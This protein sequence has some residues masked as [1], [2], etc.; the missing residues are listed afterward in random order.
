[1]SSELFSTA[2]ETIDSIQARVKSAHR[3]FEGAQVRVALARIDS[4]T[5]FLTGTM[6]F[7][8]HEPK[9]RETADYGHIRLSEFWIKGVD[10]SLSFVGR[11]FDGKESVSG[12]PI[13][14]LFSRSVTHRE[15]GRHSSS[16]WPSWV[17]E[18]SAVSIDGQQRLNLEPIPTVAKGLPPFRS[19]SEAVA[20]W[21]GQSPRIGAV[22][23]DVPQQDQFVVVIP[24]TRARL[25]SC[26]WS[27]DSLSL[28]AELNTAPESVELQVI[29][30]GAKARSANHPI[31]LGAMSFQVPED[32][33]DLA[34]YL[35]HARG[36]LLT[37]Q[38]LTQLYRSFGEPELEE[39]HNQS[40]WQGELQKGENEKREFRPFIA[41]KD[42]KELEIVKTAVAFANA[43]GGTIFVGV[44][45]EGVPLGTA[46]ANTS[47]PRIRS[48][49]K[50]LGSKL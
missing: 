38:T 37:C 3:E 23:G 32:A 2:K 24:D 20:N 50:W 7:L 39:D 10:A 49:H 36:E 30:G 1:M 26:R 29:H 34:L 18:A 46:Q 13:R 6:V 40:H 47:K 11:L 27:P 35:V 31:Q 44:D 8:E 42:V 12:I 43:D 4:S 21:I 28:Q 19:P 45:N 22:S 41:P 5:T 15:S 9:S 16:G 48:T 17:Y 25:K 33:N 14:N